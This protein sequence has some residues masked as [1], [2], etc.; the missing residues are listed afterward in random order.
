MTRLFF[1]LIALITVLNGSH[2]WLSR[3]G[4]VNP[5]SFDNLIEKNRDFS[6]RS[7][8][9]LSQTEEITEQIEAAFKQEHLSYKHQLQQHLYSN[10]TTSLV[11]KSLKYLLYLAF[12]VIIF[13][14][15]KRSSKNPLLNPA[16]LFFGAFLLIYS[17]LSFLNFGIAGVIAGFNTYVFLTYL[18]FSKD[19]FSDNDIRSLALFLLVTLGL[20]L[21]IAP[22]E[23][24]K[25]IQVFNTNSF[26]KKRM[27]GFMDQPNT[28]GVYIVCVVSFF[29]V[30]FRPQ[31]T[32]AILASFYLSVLILILL[33]GSNTAALVF[34]IFLFA[35]FLFQ[36]RTN[37]ERQKYWIV[38]LLCVVILSLYLSQGRSVFDSLAGRLVKYH[39]YFS[40]DLP[41]LKL[42]FGHGLGVGS[43]TI[44]QIQSFFPFEEF[45]Q[46]P[47]KFSV[48][49]TPLL[50][51]IQTGII[52]CT[53]FYGLI[54]YALHIDVQKRSAYIVFI[55]C[56][57][58]I[59]IIEVFPV[60][61]VLALLL[62]TSLMPVIQHSPSK[63]ESPS[64]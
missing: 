10:S 54:L 14:N 35:E 46:L 28:L 49:S 36:G 38:L 15:A 6:Q 16:V 52:G 56:S 64:F 21:L 20:L 31:L 2:F 62:S 29:V 24:L 37:T 61:I 44:L 57:L 18:I 30:L 45:A 51:V 8:I 5:I 40:L 59:N 39:Y 1:I 19:T 63:P 55:L 17:S 58:S 42:L 47:V 33:S 11:L 50:L 9:Y 3:V 34:C 27:T 32:K 43:N 53:V 25:G 13:Y 7:K 26:L 41:I 48:D 23:M 60:N 22:V 4:L 12:L